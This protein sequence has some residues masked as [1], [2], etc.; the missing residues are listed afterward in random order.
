MKEDKEKHAKEKQEILN[1]FNQIKNKEVQY[2]NEIS[3]KEKEVEVL[4]EKL[5]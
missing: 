5:R 2:K 1:T 3:R 4:N